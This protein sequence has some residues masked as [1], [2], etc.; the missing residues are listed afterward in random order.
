MYSVLIAGHEVEATQI[1]LYNPVTGFSSVTPVVTTTDGL[2]QIVSIAQPMTLVT[3]GQVWVIWETFLDSAIGAGGLINDH[4]TGIRTGAGEVLSYFFRLSTIEQ[5]R[6]RWRAIEDYLNQRFKFSGYLD[7]QCSPWDF[8]KDNFLP[9]LPLSVIAAADGLAPVL[10]RREGSKAQAVGHLTAG[11]NFSRVGPVSYAKED[12]YN[13]IQMSF[14]PDGVSKNYQRITAVIGDGEPTIAGDFSTEYS[15]ASFLRYGEAPQSFS[16]DVVYESATAAE[17][18][19]WRHRAAA[20]PY[21]VI[22][23]SAAIRYGFLR[24]GDLVLLT[25]DELHLDRYLAFVRDLQ[26]TNGR[27]IITLVLVDNPP[28]EDR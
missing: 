20:F 23:Y 24:R 13:H 8:I 5:D 19:Q 3:T 2:G 26:W 18:L 17:V 14:A 6:G 22:E 1:T 7:K 28:Q 25:D 27:P 4:Y 16:S 15:R 12:V 21:R 11:P 10:W 9:L